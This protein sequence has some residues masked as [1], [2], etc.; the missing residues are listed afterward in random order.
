MFDIH[1]HLAENAKVEVSGSID[2]RH[3]FI[4]DRAPAVTKLIP[5]FITVK[6]KDTMSDTTTPPAQQI[7][8]VTLDDQSYFNLKIGDDTDAI[9]N[10]NDA[11]LVVTV[12]DPTMLTM[13]EVG[14]REWNF[15]SSDQ[16]GHLGAVQV[17]VVGGDINLLINGTVTPSVPTEAGQVSISSALKS[18]LPAAAAP[19]VPPVTD[20]TVPVTPDPSAPPVT[21]PANPTPPIAPNPDGTVPSS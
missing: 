10:V 4:D 8:A 12:S 1:I 2:V 5:V 18:T 14:P 19:V 7:E 9:G 6:R 15:L 17:T 13:V 3:H 20:P 16:P 21:D 11:P